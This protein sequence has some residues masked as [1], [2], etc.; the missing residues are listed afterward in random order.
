LI[1]YY[2]MIVSVSLSLSLSSISRYVSKL[3]CYNSE[4][5][6]FRQQSYTGKNFMLLSHHY[7][8]REILMFATLCITYKEGF[9]IVKFH[10]HTRGIVIK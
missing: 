7:V 9:S 8:S 10:I 6:H 1:G 3:Y 2:A 4:T 5:I